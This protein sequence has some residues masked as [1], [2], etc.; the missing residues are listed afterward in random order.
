M[1]NKIIVEENIDTIQTGYTEREIVDAT[2]S[3]A[4]DSAIEIKDNS[5]SIKNDT[6]DSHND[7]VDDALDIQTPTVTIIDNKNS[8][9]GELVP[10][11]NNV[12][13]LTIHSTPNTPYFL[14]TELQN[15]NLAISSERAN[16]FMQEMREYV[17]YEKAEKATNDLL[18]NKKISAGIKVQEVG[19]TMD[20]IISKI[21]EKSST[22]IADPLE[23]NEETGTLSN[24]HFF[25]ATYSTDARGGEVY[26]VVF[27]YQAIVYLIEHA[28]RNEGKINKE[29]M[30]IALAN[31]LAISEIT[32]IAN[33]TQKLVDNH[34]LPEFNNFADDVKKA[35]FR[36]KHYAKVPDKSELEACYLLQDYA[37]VDDNG[38]VKYVDTKNKLFYMKTSL[39]NKFENQEI[40]VYNEKT[41]KSKMVNPVSLYLKSK[42]CRKYNGMEFDPS[43]TLPSDIF[44][45]FSGFKIMPNKTMDI[46]FFKDYVRD[47][48]CS[49]VVLMYMIV[50][51]FFAQIFQKP[52]EKKGTALVLVSK[53]EG[54]GKSTLMKVMGKL[55]DGYYMSSPDKKR[56]LGEFNKHLETN[57][58]FYANEVTLKNDSKAKFK[59]KNIVTETDFSSEIKGG[60][61][62]A[63]KNYT[64]IV[65]DS[66]EETVFSENDI[67][68]RLLKPT[69]CEDR[70]DDTPYWI[71]FNQNIEQDGFY[72]SL[73][74]DLTTF[75]YSEWEDYLRV[76]PKVEITD[77]Q[78]QERLTSV[79]A[80]WQSCLENGRIPYAQYEVTH[81]KKLNISNEE[82]YQGFAK[83]CKK[84]GHTCNLNSIS[85]GG[86]FKEKALGN[87]H[88]LLKKNKVTVNGKRENSHV[89]DE[90]KKC[91]K[92]FKKI[93]HINETNYIG[94]KWKRC[95]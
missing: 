84:N 32:Q 93:N 74:Y 37:L 52:W 85:F 73:M 27:N 30:L 42:F 6:S 78:I 18:L 11:A 54:S 88:K 13:A 56:F 35:K 41:G 12:S 77:E 61:T 80:W 59:F 51:S 71:E 21:I 29:F 43:N 65:I 47:I 45:T 23:P 67:S 28:S 1:E 60:D 46:T 15:R 86:V 26:P 48:I 75:D 3:I 25:D 22:S 19:G 94:K 53:L 70:V 8:I 55:M 16:S 38:H 9:K 4:Q 58:L 24:N 17:D 66:N 36:L 62:Y 82:R 10:Y 31:N 89:Y 33:I 49:G 81:D 92:S 44:N 2:T 95:S 50:W 91:R 34:F 64:H 7:V 68:R 69:V 40:E 5:I 79:S 63:T 90:L 57:I 76:P 87:N 39:Y 83:W 20:T 14:T 72:E